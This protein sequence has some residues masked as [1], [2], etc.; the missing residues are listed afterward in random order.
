[1]PPDRTRV[2]ASATVPAGGLHSERL[3]FGWS[4]GEWNARNWQG[5]LIDVMIPRM[6]RLGVVTCLAVVVIVV[7]CTGRREPAAP[8]TTAAVGVSAACAGQRDALVA[9]YNATNG[10]NWLSDSPVDNWFGVYASNDG[11]V[12]GLLLLDNQL[13]GGLPSELGQLVNLE[14][15]DLDENHLTGAIP[16]ELGKLANLEQLDLRENQLTGVIPPELGK[17]AN[18]EQLDLLENQLTGAIPP[19]LGQTCQLKTAGPL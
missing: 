7:A 1:M 2:Q 8:A 19:E 16:P 18:L 6:Y 14:W 4:H 11:C 5:L 17:L 15:L 9:L 13:S 3:E 10:D 12:N